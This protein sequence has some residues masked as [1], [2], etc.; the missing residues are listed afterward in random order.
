[1][2]PIVEYVYDWAAFFSECVYS[3]VEG[4]TTAREFVLRLRESDGGTWPILATAQHSG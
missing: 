4:V 2:H 1:M 3:E